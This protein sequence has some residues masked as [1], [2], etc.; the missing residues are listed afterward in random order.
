M[1]NVVFGSFNEMVTGFDVSDEFRFNGTAILEKLR[2]KKLIFVGDSLNRNQWISF[3]CLIDP[4]IPP[5]SNTKITMEGNF[6]NVRVKVHT[7]DTYEIFYFN[8]IVYV[9]V[10]LAFFLFVIYIYILVFANS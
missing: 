6:L 1:F 9:H 3:L 2:N 5:S 4:Y 7:P 8:L 10:N